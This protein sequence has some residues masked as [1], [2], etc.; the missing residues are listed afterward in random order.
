[1]KVMTRWD[2]NPKTNKNLEYGFLTASL[3][4]APARVAGGFDMCTRW[5]KGCLSSCLFWQGRGR[6]K[7]TQDARINRTLRFQDDPESFINRELVPDLAALCRKAEQFGVAPAVRLNCLTDFPWEIY[8]RQLM[9]DFGHV[10]FYDYTKDE[11]RMAKF[12]D[13][14]F[15]KNYDLTFSVSEQNLDWALTFLGLNQKV[16]LV[17]EQHFASD[18][19]LQRWYTFPTT[20][21]DKHDLTFLHRGPKVLLLRPKGTATKDETGFVHREADE[22]R[23]T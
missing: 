17:T 15:P 10:Q 11:V 23:F 12:L 8:R 6:M 9:D 3:A 1:M 18:N 22:V 2:A 7:Q 16:A 20:D 21:G 14:E 19:P 5:T 13:G 4:L